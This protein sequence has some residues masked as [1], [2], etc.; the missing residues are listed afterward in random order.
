MF[1]KNEEYD[2]MVKKASRNSKKA[3]DFFL[4]FLFG[5]LVCVIGE[6]FGRLYVYLGADENTR[7]ILVALTLITIAALLTGIKLF[8]KIS[9]VAGA[10]VLVPIT[11]FSNAI[12]APAIEFKSE[13][14][15]GGVGVKIFSIAGP[16]IMYGTI[17]SVIYGVIYYLMKAV[18]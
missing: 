16:V 5:G 12:V 2:L 4:A 3:R 13:G 6:L 1:I 11:G 15:I 8:Q 7:P 9:K 10:G 14:F 17:A 18:F